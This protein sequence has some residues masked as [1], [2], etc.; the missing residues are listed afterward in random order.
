MKPGDIVLVSFPYA[1]QKSSKLRPGLI[2]AKVPGKHSDVLIAAISSRIYQAL[3][4]FD[5]L[6]EQTDPDF[7]LTG[8]KVTSVIR[9]GKLASVE[10]NIIAAR[11]GSISPERLTR[12][13]Q[14]LVNWLSSNST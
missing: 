12:V 3:P 2:I 6:I 13:H 7:T 4:D 14:G 1:D 10:I 8:L 11:L 9:I 5:E